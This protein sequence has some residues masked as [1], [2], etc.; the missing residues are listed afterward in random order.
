MAREGLGIPPRYLTPLRRTGARGHT[1]SRRHGDG[2]KDEA[3]SGRA[4]FVFT[5]ACRPV[6]SFPV[7]QIEFGEAEVREVPIRFVHYTVPVTNWASY[8]AALF[9]PSPDLPPCG[10]N[11]LAARTWAFVYA[12]DGRR[13]FTF[14][15]L[16]PI[17]LQDIWVGFGVGEPPGSVFVEL[18]D[19]L[20]NRRVRSNTVTLRAP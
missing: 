6:L 9:A 20:E 16:T 17:L 15:G 7:P 10:L 14:C 12:V 1:G 2:M 19:R 3:V 11:P 8:A 4:G 13:L 18:W 5:D